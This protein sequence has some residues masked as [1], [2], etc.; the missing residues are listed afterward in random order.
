[1]AIDETGRDATSGEAQGTTPGSLRGLW[2]SPFFRLLAINWLIGAFV[3]VMVL[4]GLMYFDTANLRSLILNSD[5]PVLPM[6][7][8]LFGLMITLCSAAMGAAIMALPGEDRGDSGG[9]G[10]PRE[11]ADEGFAAGLSG[12]RPALQ[13]VRVRVR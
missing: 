2:A 12:L 10:G 1:M 8:L 5:N 3:S 9:K 6:V 7:V 4:G 11:R 13:P